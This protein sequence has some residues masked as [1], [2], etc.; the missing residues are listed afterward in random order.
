M[1]HIFYVTLKPS[2]DEQRAEI[3]A[4]LNYVAPVTSE[5]PMLI[6]HQNEPDLKGYCLEPD[7]LTDAQIDALAAIVNPTGTQDETAYGIRN[8]GLW[9]EAEWC[10]PITPERET[11]LAESTE[12]L[13]PY[14]FGAD[15]QNGDALF[16]THDFPGT[17]SQ[18][19]VVTD[20]AERE[21]ILDWLRNHFA[22]KERE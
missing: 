22:E 9:L 3:A 1:T 13:R 17:W 11:C 2:Q 12:S 10:E 6:P 4:L 8:R 15:W 21:M 5:H 20:S 16:L 19:R 18:A 7:G 14:I